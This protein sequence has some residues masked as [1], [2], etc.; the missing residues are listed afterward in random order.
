MLAMTRP[1]LRAVI[2]DDPQKLQPVFSMQSD[3]GALYLQRSLMERL[4]GRLDTRRIP[5]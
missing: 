3:Q 1:G 5:C 4:F 2:P